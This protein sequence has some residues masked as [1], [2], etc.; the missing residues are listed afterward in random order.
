MSVRLKSY[1]KAAN[2]TSIMIKHFVTNTEFNGPSDKVGYGIFFGDSVT[3]RLSTDLPTEGRGIFFCAL[4]ADN[5]TIPV[6]YCYQGVAEKSPS[7]PAVV[8]ARVSFR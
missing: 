7:Q 2:Y 1:S 3:S 8:R 6:L 4:V 5:S